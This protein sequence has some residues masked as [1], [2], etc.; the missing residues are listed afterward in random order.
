MLNSHFQQYNQPQQELLFWQPQAPKY[1]Y[2]IDNKLMGN[3]VLAWDRYCSSSKW[4]PSPSLVVS[5][6]CLI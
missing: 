3:K 6:I 2:D 5:T 4:D 1:R